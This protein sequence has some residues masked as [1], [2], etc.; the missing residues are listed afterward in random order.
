VDQRAG[1]DRNAHHDAAGEDHSPLPIRIDRDPRN[2]RRQRS[3]AHDDAEDEAK[4]R[5]R[6]IE[7]SRQEGSERSDPCCTNDAPACAIVTSAS[8]P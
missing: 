2:R 4:L 6:E 7:F 3:A 8:I 5:A 1:D